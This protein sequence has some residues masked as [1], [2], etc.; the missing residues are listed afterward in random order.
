ML[1]LIFKFL[2]E[3]DLK[4]SEDLIPVTHSMKF[5]SISLTFMKSPVNDSVKKIEQDLN[6]A[7]CK[8]IAK[9]KQLIAS[10]TNYIMAVRLI[11]I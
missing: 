7:S 4:A 6:N 1:Y 3:F 5:I 8:G 2:L 9:E 11:R 10:N